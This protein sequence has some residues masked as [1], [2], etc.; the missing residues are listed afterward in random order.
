MCNTFQILV[1]YRSFIGK[2]MMFYSFF[3]ISN[4][5][6]EFWKELLF[7]HKST[8]RRILKNSYVGWPRFVVKKKLFSKFS[9]PVRDTKKWIKHHLFVYKRSKNDQNFKDL[10]QKLRLPCPW[11]VQNW[12]GRGGRN[13][14]ATTSKFW[15]NSYFLKIFKW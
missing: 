11:Q 2:Q 9:F 12:N 6:A 10:A 14:W 5:K 3:C 8:L 1:N 13:F 4:R 15:E 7:H